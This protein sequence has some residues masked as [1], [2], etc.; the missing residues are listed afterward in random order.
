MTPAERL[1]WDRLHNRQ[2]GGYKFR[3]QHPLG[4]FIA[5]FHCADA[6]LVVEIDGGV[7]L[8]TS[9][10]DEERTRQFNSYG[11][12]VIRF[13]Y[14]EVEQNLTKVLTSI[15]DACTKE[16]TEKPEE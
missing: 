6:R 1:L 4:P 13:T 2:L 11:Y 10:H 16:E 8:A 12:R 9:E 5:D 7:H 3:R 14:S 15:Q